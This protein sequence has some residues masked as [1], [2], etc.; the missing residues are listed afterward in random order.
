MGDRPVFR[1][2]ILGLL[3]VA[4]AASA[5]APPA[6]YLRLDAG[7]HMAAINDLAADAKA[8]WMVTASQDKTA[9]V[10]DLASGRLLM[11]LRPPLADGNEGQL[12]ACAM[13][14]DG[15]LVAVG[16]WTFLGSQHGLTVYLFDRTSGRLVDRL[17]GLPDTISSLSFSPDGRWLAVGLGLKGGVRVYSVRDTKV[18]F[19][20]EGYGNSCWGLSWNASALATASEDGG[21][22]LYEVSTEGLRKVAQ[23]QSPGGEPFRIAFSP[24]GERLLLGE[25]DKGNVELYDGHTLKFL[26]SLPVP[27]SSDYNLGSVAWSSDGKFAFAGGRYQNQQ[28][29]VVRRWNASDFSSFVDTPCTQNTITRLVALPD[30]GIL[31]SSTEPAWGLLGADGAWVAK[32]HPQTKQFSLTVSHFSVSQD[33]K[34]FEYQPRGEGLFSFSL[35]R[36]AVAPG[37]APGTT[38]RNLV[39]LDIQGWHNAFNPTLKGQALTLDK[40]EEARSVAIAPDHQSL[41]LGADWYLRSFDGDGKQIWKVSAPGPVWGVNIPA[42]GDV[43]VAEYGDGTIRWHRLSDG[44]ELLAYFPHADGK[45]W[46]LWTPSGYYDASPGAEDLIGWHINRGPDHPGDFFP[47]GQ[48]RDRFYRPTSSTRC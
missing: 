20:S 24:D 48:F 28:G 16:G 3:L 34:T 29:T 17:T 36:R 46:I 6:P 37:P 8:Q 31:V 27:T 13:S 19:S 21:L 43:V 11:T 2:V 5:E 40:G 39:G 38:P 44:R 1:I 47:V 4:G 10:W 30:G 35:A 42:S 23:V 26:Q 25:N 32:G 18:S 12:R 15:G 9:K 7:M 45:R 22:R 14:P 41:V 33:A